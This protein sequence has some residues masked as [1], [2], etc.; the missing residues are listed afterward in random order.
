VNIGIRVICGNKQL[1]YSASIHYEQIA[2]LATYK[3]EL[4]RSTL[5]L[6]PSPAFQKKKKR[7]AAHVTEVTPWSVDVNAIV[8]A[9]A[10]S[11]AKTIHQKA[12]L[13]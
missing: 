6:P 9:Q 8:P 1:I 5:G 7:M 13:Y 11:T 3:V 4:L 2:T 12:Q 10:R